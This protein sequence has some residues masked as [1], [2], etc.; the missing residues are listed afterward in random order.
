MVFG[1][2]DQLSF[3][4][5]LTVLQL[6]H[7]DKTRKVTPNYRIRRGATFFKDTQVS[8]LGELINLNLV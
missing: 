3:N 5:L 8:N 6:K 1:G 7:L 2:E 4:F